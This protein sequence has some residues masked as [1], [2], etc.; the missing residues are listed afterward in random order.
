MVAAVQQQ[1][2]IR[3]W[4]SAAMVEPKKL[5]SSTTNA[6]SKINRS[7]NST[8]DEQNTREKKPEACVCVC[9]CGAVGSIYEM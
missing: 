6:R 5:S 9:V 1:H 7:S 3:R 4:P 8:G 2:S